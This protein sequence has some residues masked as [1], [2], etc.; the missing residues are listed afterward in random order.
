MS[1]ASGYTYIGDAHACYPN[2]FIATLEARKTG[3]T[4]EEAKQYGKPTITPA[5][6]ASPAP[7]QYVEP[8]AAPPVAAPDM[9]MMIPMLLVGLAVVAVCVMK[10]K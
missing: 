9:D 8:V 7:H 3:I 1:C 4:P 5:T 6:T 2:T 10:K